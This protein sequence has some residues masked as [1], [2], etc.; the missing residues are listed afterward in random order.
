LSTKSLGLLCDWVL[1]FLHGSNGAWKIC[2]L[3]FFNCHVLLNLTKLFHQFNTM[4]LETIDAM[5]NI[6][7]RRGQ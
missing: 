2:K 3:L 1:L 6:K 5:N 7:T 4:S